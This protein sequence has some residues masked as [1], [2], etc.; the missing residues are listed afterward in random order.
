MLFRHRDP[1]TPYD[2]FDYKDMDHYEHVLYFSVVLGLSTLQ[3]SLTLGVLIL[4]GTHLTNLFTGKTTSERFGYKAMNK[5]TETNLRK[6]VRTHGDGIS[7]SRSK[8]MT[9]GGSESVKRREQ[10]SIQSVQK[11]VGSTLSSDHYQAEIH[12]G[13]QSCGKNI[14]DMLWGNSKNPEYGYRK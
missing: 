8:I 5:D 4:T 3:A 13:N 12:V 2:Y 6:S 11:I 9:N 1:D 14:T 7:E 10:Q